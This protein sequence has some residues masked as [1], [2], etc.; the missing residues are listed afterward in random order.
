MGREGAKFRGRVSAK[1]VAGRERRT[2]RTGSRRG[3][4]L[5][6]G[7]VPWAVFLSDGPGQQTLDPASGPQPLLRGVWLQAAQPPLFAP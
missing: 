1:S 2:S 7:F 4:P 5:A 3:S 6:P